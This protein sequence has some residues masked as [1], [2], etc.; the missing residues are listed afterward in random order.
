[1]PI[2]CEWRH[3]LRGHAFIQHKKGDSLQAPATISE[4]KTDSARP[5]ENVGR[6]REMLAIAKR[7]MGFVAWPTVMAT[8]GALAGVFIS[9]AAA[10]AGLW[11]FWAALLLN[12]YLFL[13]LFMGVHEA[14][15]HAICGDDRRFLWLND[16]IGWICGMATLVPYRGYD[17][18]HKVHHR[19]T[20]DPERDPDYWCAARTPPVMAFKFFTLKPHYVWKMMKLGLHKGPENA[21]RFWIGNLHDLAALTVLASGFWG[22][23]AYEAFMLWIGPALIDVGLISTFFNWLPHHPHNAQARYKDSAV[24]LLPKPI[25]WL[26]TRLDMF[27]TYHLMH[28]LF[29]RIP[30]YRLERAFHDMRPLL[31][32]EGAL[33]RDFRN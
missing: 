27:Q 12:G 20:N 22:G 2:T 24:F 25:H 1:L 5:A 7:H 21:K 28:H 26:A 13:V 19:Y 23:W 11:P 33:I 17:L 30:F 16:A 6:H 14:L 10:L 4:L 3:N 9:S 32:A 18:M 8:A 31:E 29:P 15:H